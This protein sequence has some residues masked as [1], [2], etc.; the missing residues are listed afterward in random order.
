MNILVLADVPSKALW[1]HFEQ[2]RLEGIDLI[3]SCGDLPA[4]Y[5][6]FLVTFAHC[7]LLYVHGN[8]DTRYSRKP[9]EGC[10]CIDDKIY[11]HEGV[12]ILGLGGSMRYKEGEWQYSEREM[13]K[14]IRKL[15]L[16]LWMKKG[17]DILLT[18]APAKGHNDQEDLAHRGF[19][20]FGTLMEKYRP[21]YMVHG[22][23]HMN[24]GREIPRES[25]YKNTTVINAF[26][27]YTITF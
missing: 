21:K 3:L 15:R 20:A 14:R 25:R 19:E 9:P 27:R 1:D 23:V 7:P 17:F 18:H 12:R 6:S 8:H 4:E 16:K 24:Y 13:E 10:I 5:L 22:H 26:E 2:S 11:T